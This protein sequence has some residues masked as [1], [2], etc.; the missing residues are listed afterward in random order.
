MG[1]AETN[2]FGDP[3]L[4]FYL[5]MFGLPVAIIAAAMILA[6]WLRGRER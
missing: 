6:L 4:S 3:V 1:I 2:T 5:T